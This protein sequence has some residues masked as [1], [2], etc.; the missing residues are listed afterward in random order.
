[1]KISEIHKSRLFWI[2]TVPILLVGLYALLGFKVAPGIA[3]SQAQKF[4]R[5]HYDRELQLGEIRIHPFKLQLEIR[6]AALP[7]VDG[8]TMLGFER[9]FVDFELSSLWRRAFVF[10]D[11]DIDAPLLRAVQRPDGGVNLA[12]LALPP[13]PGEEKSPPPSL[14]IQSLVVDRGSIEFEDNARSQPYQRAFRDVS[15]S[16]ENFRTTPQGGDFHFT[17][18]SRAGESFEWN[19]RF[20]LSPVIASDGE[21]RVTG[22]QAAGVGEFL[23]D[24]LPF[25]ISNGTIEL[26]GTYSTAIDEPLVLEAQLPEIT[27]ADLAIRA[28][29]ETEDWVVLPR[30]AVT[31]TALSLGTSTVTIEKVALDDVAAKAWLD[32][33]GSVNL[34]K[35]FAPASPVEAG[36]GATASP[37]DAAATA[38]QDDATAAKQ[39][40]PPP[41]SET[42]WS[43]A[44]ASVELN[45]GAV[46]FE[47]RT[48]DPARRFTAKPIN[49]QVGE[50]SLDL[51]KPLPV[52]VTATI[53]DHVS[54]ESSGTVTPQ[55][56]AADLDVKL[57]HA[58]M[59]ILQPYVLP[60]ADLTIKG[61]EIDLA[62]KL[63]VQPPGHDGPEVEFAGD[64]SIEDFKSVDNALK[65]DLVNFQRVQL[66]KLRF[67]LAP[68]A[69][70]I[71]R[72]T[73]TR[74]YARVIISPEQV[75]N[76]AAVLD[77]EGTA[78][79][80]AERRA[81]GSRSP[82]E[83]RRIDKEA[84][85]DRKAAATQT[86][87]APAAAGPA[88]DGMPIRVGEVRIVDGRMN[89]SD[90]YVQPN[91]SADI[92]GLSGSI[93]RL[94]SDPRSRA[95]VELSGSLGEFS[96]VS[97]Q[98]ELTPFA[99]DHY[100][101]LAM[102]FENISLPVLNPYSGRLAGYNISKGKLTTDLHYLIVDRKLDAQH[103]IRIDQLEWGEATD[104]K[105]EATLPVKFATSLLKDRNGVINLD[106]PVTGSLDDP[107]FRIGP[108]VWQIIKNII[109]KV[110]T[111][112]FAFL[113]SLFE[114]AEDAQF[115]DFAPG[116]ATLDAATGERLAALAK[117]LA[118]KPALNLDVP[119]GAI[120]EID[121]PA[122][123]Q[124][125]FDAALAAAVAEH[126]GGRKGSDQAPA[127]FS[128][129]APKKQVDVLEAL[130]QQQTGVKPEV[131]EAPEPPEGTSRSEAKALRQAAAVEYLEAQAR[132]GITVPDSALQEL[133]QERAAAVQR[134]LLA[135]GTLDP[136]RVFPVRDGK[137]STH[138]GKVRF[139]LGLE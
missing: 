23:G 34:E 118:E 64:V 54:F 109:V 26:A 6:D 4:V 94:T 67:A 43:I 90:F 32:K 82:A 57:A 120:P 59:Q 31:G 124:R 99:F 103:K 133:A 49:A 121:R 134:A 138:E 21:F 66:Q 123:E 38:E 104:T 69:L 5:E 63:R 14:W 2:V 71:D 72:I 95:Q 28:R 33:D 42:P 60:V 80:L 87:A 46:D 119:I 111:A 113:G 12:D 22:L 122:L 125:A 58:R 9:L 25:E 74:P 37:A 83:Q 24:A 11:I 18:D 68:D 16:L 117:G 76:I 55:P 35:L 41:A 89:F 8:R 62:G 92:Q 132:A 53:D 105:G 110:V 7:D 130:I 101:D 107:K 86:A 65:D 78:A 15:F 112:P 77:P 115:I 40:G 84:K 20:A 88:A 3:R 126:G 79:A 73:V 116:D 48:T 129:L 93:K 96:P 137:V 1:V 36:V 44:I 135:D 128:E 17:A 30:I 98:G 108:I 50:V 97:I 114:G 91:F 61:G 47:D 52:S 70:D 39:S 81:E 56:L 13:E 10:K 51:G 85:A 131:P 127:P 19:G 27:F 136:K 45:G 100:T 29:G 102:K 106:L 139:E 75:I